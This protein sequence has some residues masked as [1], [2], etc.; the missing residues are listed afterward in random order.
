MDRVLG[1]LAAVFVSHLHADHHTVSVGWDLEVHPGGRQPLPF[2]PVPSLAQNLGKF[3][4]PLSENMKHS[5]C[6][7]GKRNWIS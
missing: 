5:F 2:P 6:L 3:P 4:L 1:T 7:L